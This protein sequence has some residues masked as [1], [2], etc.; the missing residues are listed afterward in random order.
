MYYY[1]LD[2]T[3]LSALATILYMVNVVTTLKKSEEKGPPPI[4]II[5]ITERKIRYVCV[6]LP[7][8][9]SQLPVY[10]IFSYYEISTIICLIY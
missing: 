1:V 3:N 7:L 5:L 8:L 2:V 9:Y 6:G 10:I 4:S